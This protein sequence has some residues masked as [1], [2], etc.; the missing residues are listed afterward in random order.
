MTSSVIS[1]PNFQALAGNIKNADATT[2][3]YSAGMWTFNGFGRFVS[4]TV[5]QSAAG[6]ETLDCSTKHIFF[7]IGGTATI[8]FINLSEGQTVNVL[9]SSTGS[10]YT[11][12]WTGV[13]WFSG[14]PMAPTAEPS[15][16]DLYTFI[17]IGGMIFGA[18][19][20]NLY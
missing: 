10:G 18:Q 20:R 17:K 11:I 19:V 13:K 5:T 3:V 1:T 14:A 16:Y 7:K 8:N 2:P 6:N 4:P 12:T 9:I 15:R